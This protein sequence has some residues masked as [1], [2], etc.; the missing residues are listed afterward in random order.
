MNDLIE[1]LEKAT[2]PDR[3]LDAEIWMTLNPSWRDYPRTEAGGW[4]TPLAMSAPASPY[5]DSIDA[6]LTL[7]PKG[8]LVEIH[9]GFDDIGE[10]WSKIILIDSFSIGRSCNPEDRREI[11]AAGPGEPPRFICI[12]ALKAQ[13]AI[14]ARNVLTTGE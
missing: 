12:V 5:T 13:Q 3:E 2:G 4:I 14:A 7:M 10:F 8:W 11:V 6:A 1:R 9:R